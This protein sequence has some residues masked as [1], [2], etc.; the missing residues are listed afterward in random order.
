MFISQV[1]KSNLKCQLAGA[2]TNIFKK[3]DQIHDCNTCLRKHLHKP[4]SKTN[5]QKFTVAKKG[6]DICNSLTDNIG[7][8]Q[9]SYS[10]KHKLRISIMNK[11][12]K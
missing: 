3:N 4:L 9:S 10:F 1:S 6:V 11:E 7:D 12:V 8:S 5:A 2:L